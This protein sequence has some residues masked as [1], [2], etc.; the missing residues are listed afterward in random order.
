MTAA[1]GRADGPG[2]IPPSARG[3]VLIGL[4]VIVG[5]RRAA[6]PRRLRRHDASPRPPRASRRSPPRGR[7]A[8]PAP[9]RARSI[10]V[11]VRVYNASGVPGQAQAESD[12]LGALGWNTLEPADFGSTRTGHRRAVPQTGS[13]PTATCSRCSASGSGAV[14]GGLPVES[15]RGRRRGRLHRHPRQRPTQRRRVRRV[16][17]P[18][19]LAALGPWLADDPARAAVLVDFD[20]S[21][22]PIVDD[23]AAARGRCPAARDALA[24]PRAAAR[25]G[26][27]GERPPGAVPLP[28]SSRSTG[29][30]TSGSTAWSGWSTAS[31]WSTRAP[32][33]WVPA[34]GGR[35]RR[36]RRAASPGSSSSARASSPSRC[37]GA[38]QPDRGDEAAAAV[39][40]ASRRHGLDV[41]HAR[42]HGDGGAPTGAGRQGHG[43]RGAGAGHAGGRVRG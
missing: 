19:E 21:L 1:R 16:P 43:H 5:D 12:K 32:T 4:A 35:G 9:P 22:A 30:C 41:A 17:L 18:P 37:T 23:P 34:I 24:R 27:G 2:G 10:E 13:E 6:D 28:S 8:P 42:P 40:E 33:E 25:P 38:P 36:A 14:V 39:T 11:R 31:G 7:P 20:G 15:A 3:A 26:R 29:W